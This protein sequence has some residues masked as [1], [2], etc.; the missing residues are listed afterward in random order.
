MYD[1]FTVWML[2]WGFGLS[3]SDYVLPGFCSRPGGASRVCSSVRSTKDG[4][5]G[6][7]VDVCTYVGFFVVVEGGE[8]D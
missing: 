3:G 1:V 2:C 4:K 5:R 7:G 8:R 6:L